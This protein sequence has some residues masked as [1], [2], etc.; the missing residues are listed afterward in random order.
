[1]LAALRALL[2]EQSGY[3]G[4]EETARVLTAGLCLEDDA[5]W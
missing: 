4:V 1:M 2:A 3:L 5:S